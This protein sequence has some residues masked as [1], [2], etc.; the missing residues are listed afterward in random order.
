MLFCTSHEEA[1]EKNKLTQQW[2]VCSQAPQN[3]SESRE[4]D[5]VGGGEKPCLSADTST[6]THTHKLLCGC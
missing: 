3:F 5:M 4:R 6:H 1:E 2:T